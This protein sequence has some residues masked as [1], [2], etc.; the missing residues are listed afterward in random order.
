VILAKTRI[1]YK[2]QLLCPKGNF[3]TT[4]LAILGK[5][6]VCRQ[7]N[8]QNYQLAAGSYINRHSTE[9]HHASN[10]QPL[11]Y[12]RTINILIDYQFLLKNKN[13]FLQDGT[14]GTL[15]I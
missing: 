3:N 1:V 10:K 15:H 12:K 6:H 8:I 14:K 4:F 9:M 2:Q 7:T 13:T 11:R 5:F